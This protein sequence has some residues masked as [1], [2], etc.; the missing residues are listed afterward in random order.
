MTLR[1]VPTDRGRKRQA[2]LLLKWHA[3]NQ[4]PEATQ[5]RGPTDHCKENGGPGQRTPRGQL[6]KGV[7]VGKGRLGP[8]SSSSAHRGAQPDVSVTVTT[9]ELGSRQAAFVPVSPV[10]P[11]AD[12]GGAANT[13]SAQPGNQGPSLLPQLP[14]PVPLIPAPRPASSHSSPKLHP[15]GC[16]ESVFLQQGPVLGWVGRA[17]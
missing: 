3:H 2:R 10:S 15:Q 8:R 4:L 11:R 13:P 12:L 5:R 16:K 1:L 6:A 9:L 7:S 17:R 14:G